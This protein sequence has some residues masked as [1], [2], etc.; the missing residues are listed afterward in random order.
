MLVVEILPIGF[1][2]HVLMNSFLR[3]K[4]LVFCVGH[5]DEGEPGEG[6][7]VQRKGWIKRERRERLLKYQAVQFMVDVECSD[8]AIVT[9]DPDADVLTSE[10]L[11]DFRLDADVFA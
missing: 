3:C 10:T 11:H 5:G 4:I 8:I 6:E 7:G 2:I 1:L 9:G